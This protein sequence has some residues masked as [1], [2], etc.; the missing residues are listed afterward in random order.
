MLTACNVLPGAQSPTAIPTQISTPVPT[1]EATVPAPDTTSLPTST[2]INIW[3]PPQFDVAGSNAG[4]VL[5]QERLNEFSAEN[6]DVTITVRVKAAEGAGGLLNSLSATKLAAPNSMPSI[7]LLRYE[8]LQTAAEAD[9]IKAITM[10][11][12]QES[13]WYKFAKDMVTLNGTVYG[14]PFAGDALAL[15]YRTANGSPR[16][17]EIWQDVFDHNELVLFPAEDPVG[18]TPLTMYLSA[19]GH[20]RDDAGNPT[21]QPETLTP[22]LQIVR[23]GAVRGAFTSTVT[24]LTTYGQAWQGFAQSQAKWVIT[25]ASDYLANPLDGTTMSPLPSA[26][27]RKVSLLNGWG[28]AFTD[29]D[30]TRR[31][32]CLKLA[33]FLT[34][35]E[36]LAEWTASVGAI[37]PREDALALWPDDELKGAVTQIL[38]TS[39]LMPSQELLLEVGPVMRAALLD[40]LNNKV[41]PAEAATHAQEQLIQP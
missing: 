30:A 11:R 24:T 9:L 4:A 3:L 7:V 23:N 17:P 10:P 39:E 18:L 33:L 1:A 5:L 34:E 41:E 21:I 15:V 35:P 26:G 14:V 28:F 37:P 38:E 20:L 25:W 29:E 2:V 19:G 13:A 6:P 16:Q 31:E 27:A 12:L 8:D 22:A 36:F 40:V 32:L